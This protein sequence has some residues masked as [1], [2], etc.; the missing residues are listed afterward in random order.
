[1]VFGVVEV[2]AAAACWLGKRV[3]DGCDGL[4]SAADGIGA[5]ASLSAMSESGKGV[6]A[7]DALW[8][9]RL[10]AIKELGCWVVC[11]VVACVAVECV[12]APVEGEHLRAVNAGCLA[13]V[14]RVVVA[15]RRCSVG[16][17][18]R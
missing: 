15:D 13:G 17:A 16:V 7:W 18:G 1:M 11:Q 4:L 8:S 12:G 2:L 6:G 3:R 9:L 5:A 14:C 10:R